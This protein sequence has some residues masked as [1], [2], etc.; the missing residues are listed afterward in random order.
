V[1]GVEATVDRSRLEGAAPEGRSPTALAIRRLLRSQTAVAGLLI[2]AVLVVTGLLAPWIAP[3]EYWRI[4][5]EA[6]FQAPGAVPGHLLGTDDLGR[7]VLSRLVYGAQISLLLGVGATGVA[8]ALGI[9]VGALSG[10][11]GGWVDS[12]LQRLTDTF[13]ALPTLLVAIAVTAIVERPTLVTLFLVMGFLS[14]TTVARVVRGQ[15]LSLREND[16][17]V[18]AR[19]L[20]AGHGRILFGHLLPNCLG[21][22]VVLGTL[23]VAGMILFE[24]GLS[25][26]G[27][28]VQP[29]YPSWGRMLLDAKPYMEE[30]PWLM[31]YPGAAI[32]LTV[33]GLNFFGDGLRDAFDPRM[34]V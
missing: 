6:V 2:T 23:L 25:F 11:F 9:L 18:A 32:V 10:Y 5:R 13:M 4:S 8:V 12:V 7:D 26:L 29:P 28:G 15:I 20:G 17:A 1:K 24:A 21:P 34:K 22:I 27:L 3:H 30:S 33:L 19:S 31:V 16:Y 14:W